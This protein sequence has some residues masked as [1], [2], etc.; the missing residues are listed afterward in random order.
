MED[1]VPESEMSKMTEVVLS[2]RRDRF[3]DLDERIV[4]M[5]ARLLLE[6][7]LGTSAIGSQLERIIDDATGFPESAS[8]ENVK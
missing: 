4:T 6:Q 2:V 7:A 3:P 1:A 8:V 5:V